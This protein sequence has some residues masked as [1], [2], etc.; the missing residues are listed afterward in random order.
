MTM[1]LEMAKR[2]PVTGPAAGLWAELKSNRR[3]LCGLLL[4]VSLIAAYGLAALLDA[5]AAA[6]VMYRQDLANLGRIV[7]IGDE[8]DWPA[9]AQQSGGMRSQLEGRL[10]TAESEGVARADIQDWVSGVSRDVGLQSLDVR[11]ES[12]RPEGLPADMRRIAATVT[13]RPGEQALTAL[14]ERIARSPHLLAIDRLNVK[15]TPAPALEMVLVG[16]A[17]IGAVGRTAP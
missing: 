1:W 5:A 6:R 10:W 16:Y 7:A 12:T 2:W 3:A 14:L 4:I 9:R 11:T 8:H 13:A 15:Q 17:R